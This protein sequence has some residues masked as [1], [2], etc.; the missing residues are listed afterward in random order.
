ML[1][2]EF[3]HRGRSAD[4][5]DHKALLA[6]PDLMAYDIIH[7]GFADN[8][9]MDQLNKRAC[10]LLTANLWSPPRMDDLSA[11]RNQWSETFERVVVNDSYTLAYLGV[12]GYTRVVQF[13]IPLDHTKF[14]PLPPPD[15][16]FTIGCFGNDY[17][18]Y[19]DYGKRFRVIEQAASVAG[20][21]LVP[22]IFHPLRPTYDADPLAVYAS[23]HVLVHSAFADTDSMPV[24]EALLCGRPVITTKNPRLQEIIHDGHNGLFFDG[25]VEDLVAKIKEAQDCYAVLR[26]NAPWLQVWPTATVAEGYWR[27][28][29]EV[30]EHA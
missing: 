3:E 26:R 9:L 13:P 8:V 2:R 10:P 21:K 11:H 29:E 5:L 28:F 30:V 4:I 15:G 20:C 1:K 24:R 6:I 17:N 12:H 7:I 18:R 27:M 22:H 16:P 23:M 25:G 14:Y 19:N